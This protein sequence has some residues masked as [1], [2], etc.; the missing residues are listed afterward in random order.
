MNTVV[1]NKKYEEGIPTPSGS[2]DV[3]HQ[4][5]WVPPKVNCT[6]EEGLEHKKCLSLPFEVAAT[7]KDGGHA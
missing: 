3:M 6:R 1:V 5:V 4:P 7:Y 2:V